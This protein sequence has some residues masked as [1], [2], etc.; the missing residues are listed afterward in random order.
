[1]RAFNP[2][3]AS[4]EVMGSSPSNGKALNNGPPISRRLVRLSSKHRLLTPR[5]ARGAT[6]DAG[7]ADAAGGGADAEGGDGSEATRAGEEGARVTSENQR[8]SETG[9]S[10]LRSPAKTV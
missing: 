8:N 6:G 10:V 5:G 7:G 1:M 9:R 2:Q 4:N 3:V